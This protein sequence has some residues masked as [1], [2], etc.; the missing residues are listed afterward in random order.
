MLVATYSEEQKR[1]KKKVQ[2]FKIGS[3][4]LLAKARKKKLCTRIRRSDMESNE[5]KN[6]EMFPF[7]F[8]PYGWIY[9]LLHYFVIYIYAHKSQ[10]LYI[11]F[12]LLIAE[13][14]CRKV[15]ANTKSNQV[16][17]TFISL[18]LLQFFV[19]LFSAES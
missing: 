17:F 10:T 18:F 16:L 8:L 15:R 19:P 5:R 14:V 4:I 9:N 6:E 2:V 13:R 11:V 1:E 7:F 3:S 12:I